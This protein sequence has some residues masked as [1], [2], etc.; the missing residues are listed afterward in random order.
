MK[1]NTI[2]WSSMVRTH[3]QNFLTAAKQEDGG[4]RA[5][6]HQV[7]EFPDVFFCVSWED[8]EVT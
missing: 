3:T 1:P 6:F 5:H 4:R 7:Y 2:N 8:N